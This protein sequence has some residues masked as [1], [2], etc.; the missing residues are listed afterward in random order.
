[1]IL[2]RTLSPGF[3]GNHGR[4]VEISLSSLG[5]LPHFEQVCSGTG[6]GSGAGEGLRGM[7]MIAPVGRLQ[8]VCM[9]L[10]VVMPR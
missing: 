9:M 1:M 8:S 3:R 5:R 7:V 2:P 4:R 10:P 6:V